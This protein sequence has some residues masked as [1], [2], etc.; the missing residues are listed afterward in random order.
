MMS[1]IYNY[2]QEVFF[3]WCPGMGHN[4]FLMQVWLY[5]NTGNWNIKK[6]KI[7]LLHITEFNFPFIFAY[8]HEW[9]MTDFVRNATDIFKRPAC[10]VICFLDVLMMPKCMQISR[11]WEK[12]ILVGQ[13]F[14]EGPFFFFSLRNVYLWMCF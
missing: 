1:F 3:S 14:M 13:A 2:L 11:E 12:I 6:T 8:L 4:S 7:I 10:L 5:L 9:L